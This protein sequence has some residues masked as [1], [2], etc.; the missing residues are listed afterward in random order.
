MLWQSNVGE[1]QELP[2]VVLESIWSENI[3]LS[4]LLITIIPFFSSVVGLTLSCFESTDT[5]CE[6]LLSHEALPWI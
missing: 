4:V 6:L 2:D 3:A 5:W 1:D